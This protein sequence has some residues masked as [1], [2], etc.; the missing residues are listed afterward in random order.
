[1]QIATQCICC[2]SQELNKS[3]AILMPFV[4]H[5][6]FG[7]APVEITADWGL[8]DIRT[9]HA[10]MLCHSVQ[11]ARCETLFLDMRFDDAEMSAL[12]A[13]YRDEAYTRLRIQYEPGYNK[14]GGDYVQRAD[15]IAMI[16]EFLRPK[17]SSAPRILDWGGDTGINTPLLA[18][19]S[20]VHV[21]DISGKPTV[22][23]AAAVDLATLRN[24]K[25]D[26]IT[27]IQV[28][29]HVTDPAGFVKEMV[30]NMDAGTLL[31]LE[32]PYE[33]L[34][35]EHRGSTQAHQHKR[36]WHEHINFFSEGSMRTLA[37]QAGLEI[38]ELRP[39]EFSL[40]ERQVCVLSV[41]CRLR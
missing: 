14:V 7:Y 25:Y 11:C 23:G 26:L 31:Y 38:V 4:A 12:Y 41:L 21:Y 22:G 17:F 5:R 16:E 18:E 13:N 2:G 19:A 29:E 3:P 39:V 33:A 24:T 40:G 8:R 35:R 27:C 32:V 15:Y 10:Y 1:M 28:L 37:Q 6:V 30:A 36:H 9:G 20:L 34:M